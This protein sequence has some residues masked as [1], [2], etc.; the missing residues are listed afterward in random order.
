ML[1]PVMVMSSGVMTIE[2]PPTFKVIFRGDVKVISPASVVTVMSPLMVLSWLPSLTTRV[3]SFL[4]YWVW[5]PPTSCVMS[6]PMASLWSAPTLM[7]RLAPTVRVSSFSTCTSMSR[8][9]CSHTCSAPFLSSKR[10][11]LALAALPCG[12]DRDRM[13]LWVLLAGKDHGGIVMAF[14]T[15]PVIIGRSGLPSRNCTMTSAPTRGIDVMP[16][17]WPDHEVATRTQAELRSSYSP[18]RS[19]WNCRRTR[20][21]WSVWISSPAGPTTSAVCRP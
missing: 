11:A 2:L 5:K 4:T 6:L 16:K 18:T 19:Q 7:V 3:M 21:Y 12:L 13:P 10:M 17:P 15:M 20:P 14:G 9:A 1:P 8:S